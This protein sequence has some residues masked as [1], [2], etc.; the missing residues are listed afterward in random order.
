MVAGGLH[1]LPM[2]DL[3]SLGCDMCYLLAHA[4]AEARCQM[5][6]AAILCKCSQHE[7]LWQV[8]FACASNREEINMAVAMFYT[9]TSTITTCTHVSRM[10]Q[11]LV[12][13]VHVQNVHCGLT[14]GLAVILV[15]RLRWLQ[16]DFMYCQCMI[17]CH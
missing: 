12:S 7:P 11:P 4:A 13:S 10:I 16:G 17:C 2:H 1:V 6:S 14:A 5:K 9:L 3:L 8:D 15:I